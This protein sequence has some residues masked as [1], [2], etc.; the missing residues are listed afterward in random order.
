MTFLPKIEARKTEG[1]NKKYLDSNKQKY[2]ST[3]SF[4][5]SMYNH[6]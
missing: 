2:L 4:T 5:R 1:K 3:G 6:N